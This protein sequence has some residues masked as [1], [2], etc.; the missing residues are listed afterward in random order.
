MPLVG[1]VVGALALQLEHLL[2][3]L[4]L[5]VHYLYEAPGVREWVVVVAVLVAAGAAAVRAWRRAPMVLFGLAWAALTYLPYSGVVQQSR[6]TSDS[7]M[8]LPLAGLALA[9]AAA[10]PHLAPRWQTF[11]RRAALVAIVVYAPLSFVNVWDWSDGG[12]S[13]WREARAVTP[14][15]AFYALKLGQVLVEQRRYEE[16]VEVF[17]S[18]DTRIYG[19]AGIPFPARYPIAVCE[20]GEVDRCEALFE[21]GIQRLEA[22]QDG[23]LTAKSELEFLRENY[24]R[25]KE[26]YGR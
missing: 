21:E 25:F 1:R 11:A 9:F 17:E 20:V 22:A 2:V 13:L 12:E 15:S 16:A 7:Y 10:I 26:H 24:R 8:Y 14:G 23:S 4:G 5:R 6:Y 18:V 19:R 3:P